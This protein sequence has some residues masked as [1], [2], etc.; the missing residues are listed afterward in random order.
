MTKPAL[1]CVAPRAQAEGWR[2]PTIK[3]TCLLKNLL[4]PASEFSNVPKPSK[5]LNYVAKLSLPVKK[6]LY[7]TT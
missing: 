4:I 1:V 2:G 3:L 6:A 5:P 7:S